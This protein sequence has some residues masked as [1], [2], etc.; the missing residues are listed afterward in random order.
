LFPNEERKFDENGT[1]SIL[2]IKIKE[3]KLKWLERRRDL[4]LI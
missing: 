4:E 3:I 2:S 1:L